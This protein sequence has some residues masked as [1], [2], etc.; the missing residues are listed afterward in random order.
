MK[1][2]LSLLLASL[3]VAAAAAMLEPGSF[4]LAFLIGYLVSIV[5]PV[6]VLTGVLTLLVLGLYRVL[7]GKKMVHWLRMMWVIWALV[8]AVHFYGVYQ[9]QQMRSSETAGLGSLQ[10]GWPG[11]DIEETP[12]PVRELQL[13]FAQA[14]QQLD[15]ELAEQAMA[16]EIPPLFDP[17]FV[18][19]KGRFP[20]A[21]RQLEDYGQLFRDHKQKRSKLLAGLKED[22]EHLDLTSDE[23]RQVAQAFEG[24]YE[25]DRQLS[26]AYFDIV[27]E[28]SRQGV[29]YLD[30]MTRAGYRVSGGQVQLETP[31]DQEEYETL[32]KAFRDLSA[33]EQTAQ[34]ELKDSRE[35]RM[36]RLRELSR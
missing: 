15:R 16:I 27:I 9:H 6:V 32:V 11:Q 19:D 31:G 10:T 34:R 23:K 7:A 4:T 20:A 29:A 14:S 33:R 28:V 1:N 36:A 17:E 2:L 18:A 21:A 22:L 24:T 25:L 30:F 35:A 26:E 13:Q 8:A 3:A 5:L 12:S